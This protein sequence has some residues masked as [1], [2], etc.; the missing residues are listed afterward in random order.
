MVAIVPLGIIGPEASLLAATIYQG[1]HDRSHKLCN[2]VP[3]ER[4]T[5]H[6]GAIECC[7]ISMKRSQWKNLNHLL[8]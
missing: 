5:P 8:S 2:I 4:Y 7:Y 6:A 3:I 1:H